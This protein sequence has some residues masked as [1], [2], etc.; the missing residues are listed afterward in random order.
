MYFPRDGRDAAFSYLK[1]LPTGDAFSLAERE[2]NSSNLPFS[3]Y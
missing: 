2:N 3:T 1:C